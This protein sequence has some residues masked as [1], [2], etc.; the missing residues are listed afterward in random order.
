MRLG[1]DE[2]LVLD[3]REEGGFVGDLQIPGALRM[4]LAELETSAGVLPDDELIV[5]CGDAE[6]GSDARRAWR[7]LLKANRHAVVL[8]GGLHHWISHGFPT[9]RRQPRYRPM[10][11][12]QLR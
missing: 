5:L 11:P 12:I 2:I 3:C 9:E 1:E 7:A 6:D 4:P 8:H 10:T